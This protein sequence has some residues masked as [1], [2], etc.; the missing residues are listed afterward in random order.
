MEKVRQL[1]G[2]STL[3]GAVKVRLRYAGSKVYVRLKYGKSTV[4][5]SKGTVKVQ[6]CTETFFGAYCSQY[7]NNL[8]SS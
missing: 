3:V 2:Y 6:Y 8:N 1:C 5:Y 7:L 4:K